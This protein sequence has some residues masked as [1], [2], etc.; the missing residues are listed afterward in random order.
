VK[1]AYL[2]RPE[3]AYLRRPEGVYL[4]RVAFAERFLDTIRPCLFFIKSLLV[5]PPGVW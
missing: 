2:R 3:G 5:S 1:G 4:R